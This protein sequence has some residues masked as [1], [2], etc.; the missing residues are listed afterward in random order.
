M[1]GPQQLHAGLKQRHLTMIAIGGVIGAGLFV[2]SGVVINETGPAAFL[3]YALAGVLIVMVMRMLGEMATA[4]P[5]TGSFT[6]YARKA[7]GGWA[8]FS[9]AWLY[10]YFWVIVVG[11]EAVA[12]AKILTFWFDA[13]LWLMSLVLMVLMTATNV[14]SVTSFGEFEFW[15]AGIKVATIIA[16][17]ALGTAFV[18]GL[19]PNKG[20]D[21][22]NLTA[23]GGFLPHGASSIVTAI[24]V[25]IFSMV[26]AEIATIAA[27][28]SDN[29]KRAIAKATNSVV[30]RI[31]IFFVGSVF[32]LSVILPWNSTEVGASPYVSAMKAMGIPFAD[33][34]M[35]AVVLTAVLSCLNSGLYTAS[36]MLFVL[37]GRR[38]APA[39]MTRVSSRGVP[40]VAIL[41][42]TLVGYLCVIA[43]A[44]SPKTI[45][46]FLLNSSGAV[47]LF[48]YLLIA[49]SQVVLR[50]RTAPDKLIV[51]MWFHPVLS[52]L[53]ITAILAVLLQMYLDKLVRPQLILS[54]LV[55]AIMLG[56]Y[57]IIRWR[58]GSVDAAQPVGKIHKVNR[59][60]VLA[61]ENVAAVELLDELQRIDSEGPAKYFVCAPAN[62]V[63]TGATEF[64]GAVWVEK[65]SVQEARTRLE[66]T[67]SSL[68]AEGLSAKGGFGDRLP[69]RALEYAVA[70]FTP[71][72]IVIATYPE[73]S[74]PWLR[75]DIVE[76]ARQA[77]PAIPVT[78]VVASRP[79]VLV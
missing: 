11:F 34:I 36:R 51:K 77:Y 45:F 9:A 28:E 22:S 70:A 27:A 67:L 10:W 20:M 55:W 1:S 43:A 44:I 58:Q 42:S 49:I 16:F 65:S 71:D 66:D 15:F 54:L 6:E 56:L 68:R 74:S 19:W 57:A 5:Q 73:D 14:F 64:I 40:V 50:R 31:L 25:V 62:F 60:L 33:N 59:V 8:G 12:G 18:L 69:M 26:G 17:L 7:L 41:T 38:E 30:A 3:S 37:A 63:D 32:L 53:T 78:H 79:A 47:I 72:Q 2:G 35:N 48:V 39:L 61:N 4:D 29:P 23:N 75:H 76:R 13:P 52:I 46:L 24:V 21:F